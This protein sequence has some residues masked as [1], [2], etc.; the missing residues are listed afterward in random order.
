MEE[1]FVK[2]FSDNLPYVDFDMQL[3]KT[4]DGVLVEKIL[5]AVE[6]F[7]S[8]AMQ[9]GLLLEKEVLQILCKKRNNLKSGLVISKSHPIFDA[10]PDGLSRE[11]CIEIKCPS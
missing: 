7:Q 10:S 3:C 2:A 6:P 9:R 5:G 4:A 1:G 11:F 8:D